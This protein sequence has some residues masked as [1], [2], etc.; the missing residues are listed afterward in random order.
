MIEIAHALHP[1]DIEA[2]RQLFQ[3][4]Q[5]GLGVDLCF[6][7]FATELATLPGAYAPPSGRLLLARD[8]IR[9]LGCVALRPLT[10]GA[11][12]MKRLYVQPGNRTSGVGRQL[13][14][15]LIEEARAAGYT[16]ML[17]DTLLTMAGAQRL[18]EQLGFRDVPPYR[19]NPIEGTR[20]LGL[21]LET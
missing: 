6:Q 17:L 16:R 21:D 7:D 4:Y 9:V 2:A 8:G 3:E 15:R 5:Q 14:E 20:F 12:E 18:Y 1:A 19:H 13:V 11:C 10:D